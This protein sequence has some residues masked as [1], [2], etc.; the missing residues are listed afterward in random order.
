M[1]LN[2]KQIILVAI[3][4]AIGVSSVILR[5]MNYITSKSDYAMAFLFYER[6]ATIFVGAA[7]VIGNR[8]IQ[9]ITGVVL[10]LYGFGYMAFLV[11]VYYFVKP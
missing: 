3:G 6:L 5:K 8:T 11:R 4:L 2:K 9:R 1:K 10:L 7:S